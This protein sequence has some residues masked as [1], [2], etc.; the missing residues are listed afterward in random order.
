MVIWARMFQ[1]N[2]CIQ[3]LTLSR[4]EQDTRTHKIFS[5]IAEICDTWNLAQPIWLNAN[6]RE[7]QRRSRTRFTKDNFI[8]AIEFDYFDIQIMEE[9]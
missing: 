8:E 1:D 7:F 6:I 4:D 3:D 5:A 2:R 9:D